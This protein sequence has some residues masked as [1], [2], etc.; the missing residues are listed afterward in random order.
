MEEEVGAD[1]EALK[2]KVWEHLWA[3]VGQSGQQVVNLLVFY[4]YS[5][6]R[7]ILL[8]NVI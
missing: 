3:M 6:I 5:L 1:G 4:C 8:F 7:I 2:L